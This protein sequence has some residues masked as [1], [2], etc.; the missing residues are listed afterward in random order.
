MRHNTQQA[1]HEVA[2]LLPATPLLIDTDR[3]G[4]VLALLSL[5]LYDGVRAWKSKR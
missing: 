4:A 2:A 5:T 3:I 1:K